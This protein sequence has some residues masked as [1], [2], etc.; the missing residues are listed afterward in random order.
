MRDVYLN[1]RVRP[2]FQFQAG[3]F[4]TPFAQ[5]GGIGSTNLDFVE[6]GFQSMLYPSAASA[7]RSPELLFTATSMA[8]LC[9]T[10]SGR[11]TAKDLRIANTTNQPEF[12]GRLRFYP[13]RK[14][15]TSGSGNLPLAEPSTG[16]ARRALTN[17]QSFS[18]ALPDGAYN[19]FPQFAINGPIQRYNGEFTYIKSR[20]SL[21]GEYGQLN[22]SRV[23]MSAPS[24]WDG[25]VS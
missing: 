24:R 23:T 8:A 15:R 3:Q 9:S 19:F 20:F 18:G 7:Y 14:R 10:G 16:P 5:E 13:W 22:M 1:V 2:E 11:L 17:D 6:R 12:I 25:W 21:R 4:K